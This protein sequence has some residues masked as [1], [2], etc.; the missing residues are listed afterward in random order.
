MRPEE[1][2]EKRFVKKCEGLGITSKKFEFQSE[3]G[4]PD[5]MVFIP[6]GRPLFIEFKRPGG[7]TVS[8]HQEE[9]MK[10]MNLLGYDCYVYDNWEE[11]L[12]L[13]KEKLSARK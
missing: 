10:W 6:G 1:K 9:T 12:A 13:V 4:A 7:G 11:P 5:Q 2:V 3:K 8:Y